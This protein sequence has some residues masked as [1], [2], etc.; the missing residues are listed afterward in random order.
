MSPEQLY[1]SIVSELQCRASVSVTVPRKRGLGSTALCVNDKI[2]AMLTSKGQLVVK[3]PKQRV[4]ELLLAGRGMR[5]ELS[6]GQPL[7]EWFVAGVGLEQEWGS[8]A[9]E[10]LT[11]VG[12]RQPQANVPGAD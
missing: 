3:L 10:A 2:F 8:L 5:F 1:A 9:E 12:A 6:H 4:A 7:R 11:F